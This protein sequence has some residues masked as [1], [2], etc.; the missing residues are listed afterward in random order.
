LTTNEAIPDPDHL[1][2]MSE[3]DILQLLFQ[4]V[5][6]N[7][8]SI[9]EIR[10]FVE[11]NL[12][13]ASSHYNVYAQRSARPYYPLDDGWGLTALDTGQPFF[14]NTRDRNLSP[15]II[16]GGHWE[17]N[18]ALPLLTYAQPGMNVLDIGAHI[19][20]Y[21]VK[22]AA[23]VGAGGKVFSFEPNPAVG[24]V[25]LENIKI[26]G[27]M[28][29]V[30]LHQFALG[31]SEG[32]STLSYSHS[33]MASANLL[34]DQDADFTVNVQVRKLDSVIPDDMTI[35]LIKIDAEGYEKLIFDGASEVLARSPNCA[36]MIE[37]SLDRWER[38]AKIEDLLPICGSH[39]T[40]YAVQAD[41]TVKPM[42]A[43][44]MREFLLT[45][46][47]HE[48]YFL[49]APKPQAEDYIGGLIR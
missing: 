45:C 19:G 12:H 8:T 44:V 16:M 17:P 5:E 42:R 9:A 6:K 30:M 40:V 21:T 11:K 33:N 31:A 29:N 49:V 39:K 27:L 23:R 34:G 14:V 35:D 18:V 4:Q 36:I 26:N 25:C 22:L 13:V 2:K 37:L 32:A 28:G 47:F 43:S 46:N 41:G 7:A 15:W 3:R 48:N 10:S 24:R 20:Y 1:A 38:F